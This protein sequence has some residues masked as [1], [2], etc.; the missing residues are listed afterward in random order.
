MKLIRIISMFV[1]LFSIRAIK[2]NDCCKIIIDN[3]VSSTMDPVDVF[4]GNS[5]IVKLTSHKKIFIQPASIIDLKS[6]GKFALKILNDQT[7]IR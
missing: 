6:D 4:I 5:A 7:T 2:A 1:L 3:N